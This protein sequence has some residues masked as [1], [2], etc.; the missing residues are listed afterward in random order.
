MQPEVVSFFHEDSNTICHLVRE[1]EGCACAIVDAALDFDQ[2]A[3]RT[4][5]ELADKI[6]AHVREHATR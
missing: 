6:V 4:R 5:T 3:G 2:A 1:P